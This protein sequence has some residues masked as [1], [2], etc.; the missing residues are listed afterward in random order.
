LEINDQMIHDIAHRNQKRRLVLKQLGIK[1]IFRALPCA[2]VNSPIESTSTAPNYSYF[3]DEQGNEYCLLDDKR[4][5]FDK[6]LDCI[7]NEN[8]PLQRHAK[9][10]VEKFLEPFKVSKS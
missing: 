10:R 2:D 8:P 1:Q 9:E 4:A 6:L 7:I 5:E 3:V